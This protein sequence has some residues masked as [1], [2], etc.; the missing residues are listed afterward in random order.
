M[1]EVYYER[2]AVPALIQQRT[3]AVLGYGSQG[4]AQAQNLRDNGVKVVIGVREGPSAERARKDGFTVLDVGEAVR[5]ADVVHILVPDEQQARLYRE[6]VEPNL[7]DGAALSF[8]HGFNI[9]Y[10]QIAPPPGTDV[11]MVAPKAP[12]HAFRWLFADGQGVP[13]LLAVHQ[14]A[15]GQAEA[16]GLAFAW[17]IG[18]TR[19][20]VIKTTFQEETE[21]DLFGEQAVLC[22]GMTHLVAMGF[23]TLV[24]AGYQPEIA[25]FECLNEMKLIVDL[26]YQGGMSF[27]R[28]SISDTAEYGDLTRG[29][30]VIDEHVRAN[31]ARILQDI[32]DGTFARE[33]ILE[34]QAGRPVYR[35]LKAQQEASEVEEVGARLRAMM[36]WLAAQ[37]RPREGAAVRKE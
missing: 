7:K 32:Q 12:G 6:Q 10:G 2:D 9:H 24:K 34:N 36:P 8:S 23:E 28:Y 17:G 20:G 3:V 30:R 26:M 15:S 16:L 1:A 13:G 4:H 37:G 31:M 18:C 29:P 5:R 14:D 33:W 11:F 25:Y 35:R 22:G 21:S 19:A 27:M